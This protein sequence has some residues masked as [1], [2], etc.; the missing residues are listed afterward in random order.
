MKEFPTVGDKVIFKGVPE[1]YYPMFADMKEIAENCLVVG[2]Q[3]TVAKCQV[4]SSWVAVDL[5]EFPGTE[6]CFNLTFFEQ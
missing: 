1:L 2:Q 3:Y 5:V 4:F 6:N